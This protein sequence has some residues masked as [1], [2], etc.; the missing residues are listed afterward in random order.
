[1]CVLV[2]IKLTLEEGYLNDGAS[3][4]NSIRVFQSSFFY[5]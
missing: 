3:K 1:M 4:S 5:E 2:S